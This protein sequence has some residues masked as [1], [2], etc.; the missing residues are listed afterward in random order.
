M[1]TGAAAAANVSPKP[2]KN[3]CDMS[4]PSYAFDVDGMRTV[5]R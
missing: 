3:L 5:R 4:G 2:I 1:R